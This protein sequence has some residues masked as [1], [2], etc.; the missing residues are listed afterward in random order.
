MSRGKAI[1][2]AVVMNFAWNLAVTLVFPTELEAI[3]SSLTFGIFAVIDAFALYFIRAKVSLAVCLL[4]L[5]WLTV[6]LIGY[7]ATIDAYVLYMVRTKVRL[8]VRVC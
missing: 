5:C 4:R 7:V 8:A 6:M 3:G 2:V 1:S